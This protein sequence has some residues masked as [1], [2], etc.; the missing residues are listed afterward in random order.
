MEIDGGALRALFQRNRHGILAQF[1]LFHI[2]IFIPG[3]FHRAGIIII[4]GQLRTRVQGGATP[5]C[6]HDGGRGIQ[7]QLGS[8]IF[9][10]VTG[11]L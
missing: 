8:F 5:V 3:D 1:H 7:S 2:R 6:I 11:V 9:R 10:G 4:L